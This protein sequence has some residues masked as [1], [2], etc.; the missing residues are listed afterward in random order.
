MIKA[1]LPAGGESPLW[2][3]DPLRDFGRGLAALSGRA[4]APLGTAPTKNAVANLANR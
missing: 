3:I 4:L 2:R 1:Y